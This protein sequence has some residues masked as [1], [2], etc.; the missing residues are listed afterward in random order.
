M[1]LEDLKKSEF[2][3]RWAKTDQEDNV[4]EVSVEKRHLTQ[5][6]QSFLAKKGYKAKTGREE[7]ETEHFVKVG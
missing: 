2:Y 5:K 1:K 6:F 3:F 4:L 7:Y